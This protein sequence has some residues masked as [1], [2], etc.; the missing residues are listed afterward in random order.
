VSEGVDRMERL[1]SDLLN[2]SRVIH[3]DAETEPVDAGAA[4]AEAVKVSQDLIEKSGASVV[5]PYAPAGD[6]RAR[7]SGADFPEPDFKF[8]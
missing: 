6:G 2:Y 7:S 8:H 5:T 4:A 3:G 1:I